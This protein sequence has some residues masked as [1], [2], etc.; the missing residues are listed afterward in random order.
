MHPAKKVGQ[1][2]VSAV[3]MVLRACHS[4]FLSPVRSF[5]PPS[6]PPP[7]SSQPLTGCFG[8]GGGNASPSTVF[9]FYHNS[10]AAA[11]AI[12]DSRKK[13][14]PFCKPLVA[15]VGAFFGKICVCPALRK[16][17]GFGGFI[18]VRLGYAC[19]KD[20]SYQ[21]LHWPMWLLLLLLS[22]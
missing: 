20:V 13:D 2:S 18:W 17:L 8:W 15:P 22:L 5:F 4:R 11:A 19:D 1:K 7:H 14:I 21:I 3:C 12:P 6:I 10:T 16:H 9:L